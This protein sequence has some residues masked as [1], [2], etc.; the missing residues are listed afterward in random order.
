MNELMAVDASDRL[1]LD[2]SHCMFLRQ[3]MPTLV[4]QQSFGAL[5]FAIN[6]AQG[7]RVG[8]SPLNIS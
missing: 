8:T 5:A 2:M 7:G 1:Q 3:E 4:R 6:M